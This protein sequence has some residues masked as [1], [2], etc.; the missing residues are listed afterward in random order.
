MQT[1]AWQQILWREWRNAHD[2]EYAHNLYRFIA[3]TPASPLS[4]LVIIFFTILTGAA[5]GL[6]G[7]IVLTDQARILQ[8]LMGTGAVLGGL[9][10]LI[11]GW[12]LSWRHYLNR[13]GGSLPVGRPQ[14]W[15]GGGFLLLLLSTPIF[16]PLFWLAAIGLFWGMGGLINWLNSG[17]EPPTNEYTYRVWFFWWR[18]VPTTAEVDQALQQACTVL[19]Q[20]NVVWADYL[21]RLHHEPHTQ[22]PI[23]FWLSQLGHDDWDIRFFARRHLISYGTEAIDQLQPIAQDEAD[24]LQSTAK[25]LLKIIEKNR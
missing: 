14:D 16:G 21:E 15:L 20:A 2:E 13:L 6:I 19:P 7:G 4:L 17:A 10:G 3:D 23:T 22:Q 8:Y 11:V 9:R 5:I 25:W 18:G 1:L 24:P 12:N